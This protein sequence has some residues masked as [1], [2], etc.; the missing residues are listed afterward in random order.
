MKC[1]Q[2]IQ[3]RWHIINTSFKILTILKVIFISFL[4][5]LTPNIQIPY[6][7]L[8]EANEYASPVILELAIS[9]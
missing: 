9:T 3:T 8:L 1:V 5:S 6:Y 2:I 7:K 4:D